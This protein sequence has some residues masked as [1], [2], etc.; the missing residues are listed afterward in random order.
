MASSLLYGLQPIGALGSLN[1]SEVIMNNKALT[2]LLIVCLPFVFSGCGEREAKTESEP[3]VVGTFTINSENVPL[4]SLISGRVTAYRV[5]EVRPQV[6]GLVLKRLFAEGGYV[7]EGQQL[8]Q[9]DP[10]TYKANFAKARANMLNLEKLALRK[11][12]LKNQR[13]ISDQDYEDSLYAWEQAKADTELARLNLEYC[14]VKAPLSGKIGRSNITEGALVTNGQ[15]QAMAVINQLDPIF[16]DLTPA[17]NQILKVER[18]FDGLADAQKYHQGASVKLFLEDGSAYPL[19]GTIKFLNNSVD[20]ATGTVTLR[21]EFPNP[22]HRLLPG[23]FVRAEITEGVIDD[24][25]LV[26]QQALTRDLK[27][28]AQVWVI[29]ADDT[30]SLRSVVADRTVGNTWL[31]TEGLDHGERVVTQGLQKLTTGLKVKPRAATN[32]EIVL[33]YK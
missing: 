33:A 4:T 2:V 15:A 27:G 31:V 26:P 12:N 21:A 23:M 20:E 24:G 16:I 8:Y 22:D 18:L 3:P 6:S 5:A 25:I 14:Q 9:I 19:T 29:N 30:V 32:L 17:M 13:S 28:G 7:D 1:E 11:E 10:D